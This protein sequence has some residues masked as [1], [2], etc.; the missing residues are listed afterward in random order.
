[1][2]D[3]HTVS[4]VDDCRLIELPRVRHANGSL[5]VADN[6]D[7]GLPFKVCRVYYLYDVPADAERGGHSHYRAAGLMVAL[8]GSFNVT[9]DDGVRQRTFTLNRPY[10]ALYVPTGLWRTIS[11][12]SGG[13]ICAVL[14]SQKYSEADYVRSRE[15]FMDLTSPKRK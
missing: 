6:T 3:P 10:R 4:S 13:A 1:M 15:R 7:P 11:N 14:T 2:T 8:T 12:F 5:T 9:L